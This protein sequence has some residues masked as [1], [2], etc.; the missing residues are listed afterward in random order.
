MV[1]AHYSSRGGGKSLAGVA[2]LGYKGS[3]NIDVLDHFINVAV[4]IEKSIIFK[5]DILFKKKSNVRGTYYY[6]VD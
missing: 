1:G 2:R 3:D 4:T 6:D 5:R